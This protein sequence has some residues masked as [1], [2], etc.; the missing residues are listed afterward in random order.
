TITN[1]EL[2]QFRKECSKFAYEDI[3]EVHKRRHILQPIA[4]E[5]FAAD[6]RNY[7]LVFVRKERNKI[8]QRLLNSATEL[9]DSAIH[10]VSGQRRS[11]NIEQG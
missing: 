7:L 4:L 10:S 9:T 6:G 2:I 8:Y 5:L 3:K 11:I 1:A